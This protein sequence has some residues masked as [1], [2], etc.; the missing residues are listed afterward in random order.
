MRNSYHITF[1]HGTFAKNTPWTKSG[2]T[3]REYLVEHVPGRIEFH[4]FVWS[5]WPSHMARNNAASRL[6]TELFERIHT[7]PTACHCVIAHSHGGNIACYAARDPALAQHL[8]C[9]VTLS[10]PFLVLRQRA[11]SILGGVSVIGTLCLLATGS[12]LL[13]LHWLFGPSTPHEFLMLWRAMFEHPYGRQRW[14]FSFTLLAFGGLVSGVRM[15]IAWWYRWLSSTLILPDLRINQLLIVRGPADE[16]NALLVAAQFLEMLVTMFWG[17]YGAVDRL[18]T[19]LGNWGK[20]QLD[21]PWFDGFSSVL[22]GWTKFSLAGLV[23]LVPA[24]WFFYFLRRPEYVAF[25]MGPYTTTAGVLWA[26]I[27]LIEAPILLGFTVL[28]LLTIVVLVCGST[29]GIV[30]DIA[31]VCLA[32]VMLVVVPELGPLATVLAVSTEPSPP[33]SFRVLQVRPKREFGV[34]E[35]LMHSLTYTH[36]TALEAIAKFLAGGDDAAPQPTAS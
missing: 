28:A 19:R 6:R 16:A 2:S 21:R 13:P 8:D 17:H 36:P 4:E 26:C 22:Q 32:L 27:A 18:L 20:E 24:S 34:D 14:V 11:L 33:G 29:I 10:T 9:I 7:D 12:I 15:L 23:P 31:I 3:L 35:T 1:V 30:V 5:G 25:F